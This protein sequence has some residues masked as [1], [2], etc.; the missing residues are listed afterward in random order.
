[1]YVTHHNYSIITDR[2]SNERMFHGIGNLTVD[3][4][5]W[6]AMGA[7]VGINIFLRSIQFP[8]GT[9]NQHI[10]NIDYSNIGYKVRM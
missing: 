5:R 10:I 6:N 8:R 3:C 2:Q 4:G 1:M 7:G 9:S